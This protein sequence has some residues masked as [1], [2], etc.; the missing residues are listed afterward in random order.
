MGGSPPLSGTSRTP[1]RTMASPGCFGWS[2]G[3]IPPMSDCL[4]DSFI[5]SPS[6]LNP[7]FIQHIYGIPKTSLMA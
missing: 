6:T 1:L 2:F 4:T 3:M 5:H 7:L